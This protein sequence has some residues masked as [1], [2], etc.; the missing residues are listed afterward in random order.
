MRCLLTPAV[1]LRYNIST[2]KINKKWLKS[3][4]AFMPSCRPF[5]L[6][7]CVVSIFLLPI[8]LI[9]TISFRGLFLLYSAFTSVS[10]WLLFRY[11]SGLRS[12]SFKQEELLER[13]N[14]VNDS[15]VKQRRE[16]ASAQERSVLYGELKWVIEKVNNDLGLEAVTHNLTG[17]AFDLIARQKGTC[18]LYLVDQFSRRL[19][20]FKTRKEDKRSIIK[21]KEGDIFDL[22]VMRHSGNL[23][24]EDTRSDF[25][26][27]IEKAGSG[28]SRDVRSLVSAPLVSDNSFLGILRLDNPLPGIYTQEDLRLLSVICG[29]GAVAIENASLFQRTKEFAIHDGLTG[30]YTKG[31]LLERLREEIRRS[32]RR[33]N[34]FF[35]L[36]MLDIDY[37]KQYNDNF[38]HIA[39]DI[40][41]KNLSRL[42]SDALGEFSPVISRF[43]GEEFCVILPDTDKK[44]GARLAEELR[45]EIAASRISLRQQ[46]EKI[47][48]SIG[49]SAFPTDAGYE[50]E[51]IIK[52]DKAMYEAK[53]N[54]RNRVVTA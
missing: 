10:V 8:F 20:L 53:N 19:T 18:A 11:N 5:F 21:E 23:L 32:V 15:I 37:F 28:F 3:P 41:L 42:L 14:I 44:R 43:G 52:A 50:D 4:G 30:L 38:G 33:K 40:V 49:L 54:G 34:S 29:I 39:G 7:A 27:D 13:V 25:R 1:A 6:T 51:L 35:S 26:F 46:Q 47:T 36:L 2:M 12:V 9:K 31:Y 16:I 22:W 45:A 24:V 48:V 17:V